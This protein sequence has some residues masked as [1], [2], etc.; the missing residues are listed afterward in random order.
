MKAIHNTRDDNQFILQELVKITIAKKKY[1][2]KLRS[3]LEGERLTVLDA[4]V[5]Q[6]DPDLIRK[7][8]EWKHW[9]TSAY[10]NRTTLLCVGLTGICWTMI[11]IPMH[12]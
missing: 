1:V 2:A 10:A 5:K 3:V 9:S 12:Q 8:M 6:P 7:E 4:N 11:Y